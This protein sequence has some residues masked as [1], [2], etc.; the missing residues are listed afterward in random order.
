MTDQIN[1]AERTY[2]ASF[3]R[4]LDCWVVYAGLGEEELCRCSHD[5]VDGILAALRLPPVRFTREDVE[6]VLVLYD[7]IYPHF[8]LVDGP[9]PHDQH[10]NQQKGLDLYVRVINFDT[11]ETCF[12]KLYENKRGL[13]FKHTGYSPMYLDDFTERATVIPFQVHLGAA[14]SAIGEVEHG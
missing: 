10:P 2:G 9:T 8:G 5:K 13:H 1:K 3:R 7:P 11:G 6:K 4:D 12:K 14:L